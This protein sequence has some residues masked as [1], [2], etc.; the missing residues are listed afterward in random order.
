MCEQMCSGIGLS[1]QIRLIPLVTNLKIVE[2]DAACA[3]PPP[4]SDL[5]S[6]CSVSKGLEPLYLIN[7]FIRS[8]AAIVVK[9]RLN[10]YLSKNPNYY[11]YPS[12]DEQRKDTNEDLE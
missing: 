7:A 6:K 4:Q 8:A 2:A 10:S 12:H 5:C 9:H 1:R 11:N 3:L